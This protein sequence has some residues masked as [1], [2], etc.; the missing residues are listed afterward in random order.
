[1]SCSGI[2]GGG[3]GGTDWDTPTPTHP[4]EVRFSGL[5]SPCS[6]LNYITMDEGRMLWRIRRTAYQMVR[7]RGYIVPAEELDMNLEEFLKVFGENP[8]R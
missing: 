3:R 2:K 6:G 1:M 5:G 7:D 4:L 8:H